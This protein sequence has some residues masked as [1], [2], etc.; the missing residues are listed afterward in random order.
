MY[1]GFGPAPAEAIR[2]GEIGLNFDVF[3]FYSLLNSQFRHFYYKTYP[4]RIVTDE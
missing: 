4:E 2:R 1:S 3:Y